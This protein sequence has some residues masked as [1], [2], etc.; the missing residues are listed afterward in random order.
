MLHF[1]GCISVTL[2]FTICEVLCHV[3]FTQISSYDTILTFIF[4]PVITNLSAVIRDKYWFINILIITTGLPNNSIKIKYVT[5][6]FVVQVQ[7]TYTFHLKLEILSIQV[8]KQFSSKI[9]FNF[10]RDLCKHQHHDGSNGKHNYDSHFDCI[11]MLI[12]SRTLSNRL[13]WL[14]IKMMSWLTHCCTHASR[15]I[16]IP[17]IYFLPSQLSFIILMV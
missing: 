10:Q 4:S 11:Y 15:C 2:R 6:I 14:D 13:S 12:I 7:L 16:L 9:F 5:A 3:G 17:K 8:T 1:R